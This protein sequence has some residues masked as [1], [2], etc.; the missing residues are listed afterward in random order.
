M[1]ISGEIHFIKEQNDSLTTDKRS[2]TM[3][4]ERKILILF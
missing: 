3:K 4:N 2:K 1:Q